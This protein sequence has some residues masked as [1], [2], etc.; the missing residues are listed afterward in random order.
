MHASRERPPPLE[1][2]AVRTQDTPINNRQKTE[3]SHNREAHSFSSLTGIVDVSRR[4]HVFTIVLS[5]NE[6]GPEARRFDCG[7]LSTTGKGPERIYVVEP[8]GAIADD[9]NLTDKKFPGNPTKSYRSRD[10]LRVIAEVTNWQGHSPERLL[11]M[12]DGIA[13]AKAVGGEIID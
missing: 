7:R 13:H 8:T 1:C 10:P 12:R 9:P 11:R 3:G 5:R 2:R 4:Q 6:S